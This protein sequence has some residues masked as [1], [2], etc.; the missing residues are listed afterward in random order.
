MTYCSRCGQRLVGRLAEPYGWSP[1]GVAGPRRAM[2]GGEGLPGAEA[3]AIA[4]D[5]WPRTMAWGI[6]LVAIAVGA[7]VLASRFG[8]LDAFWIVFWV[9]AFPYFTVC[10]R[11]GAS[12]GKLV[13]SLKVIS[14]DERPIDWGRAVLR[15]IFWLIGLVSMG[16]GLF[17][18]SGDRHKQGWHDKVSG[19][20]VVK[21]Q[22]T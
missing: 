14:V 15:S 3:A 22:R 11:L 6:D 7:S 10:N 20:I 21:V 16:W 13:M 18:I 4:A 8:S 12:M 17:S 19:T 2:R 9:G 1:G 5:F